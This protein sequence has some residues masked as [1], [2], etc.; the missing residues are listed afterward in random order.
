M[1]GRLNGRCG[2]VTGAG[3]GIG[4]ATVRRLREDGAQVLTADLKGDVDLLMDVAGKD[5]GK[6]LTEAALARFGRL[7]FVVPCAGISAFCPLEGHSDDYF[8]QV[9]AVN[10]TAVFRL[11]RDAAPHLRASP[12][13][14]IVTIG[15]V[16]SA[17]GDA[18]LV[19]YGTSK[20]AVLGM[21]RA[22]AV[23]L[24]ADGVTANCVMPGAI[25]TPMTAPAFAAMPEYRT[26]W[27]QKSALGR[28]G[29]P[30]D[31]ADVIAFLL[32]DDARF[33]TGQGWMVDG[34][35]MTRM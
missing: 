18:G 21:T 17:F 35:A 28:L 3:S 12:A 25:D 6:T 7:D 16:T 5:A 14:R 34:G 11:I 26:H 32:S 23:E 20:H 27:E 13:G 19:A 22:L 2:I 9:M 33:V 15:S 10:V 1:A 4:A 30:E 24:G 29:Q 8:E 31:I